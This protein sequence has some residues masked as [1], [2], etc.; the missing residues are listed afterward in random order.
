M[1]KNTDSNEHLYQCDNC[2]YYHSIL[3]EIRKD[4]E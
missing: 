2:K 1:K 3:Y 4:N